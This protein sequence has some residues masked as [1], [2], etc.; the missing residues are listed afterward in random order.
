MKNYGLD[1]R[2]ASRRCLKRIGDAGCVFREQFRLNKQTF[3][4]LC[5]DL[6]NHT[7]LRGTREI[8]VEIKPAV[9]LTPVAEYLEQKI[10]ITVMAAAEVAGVK[11]EARAELTNE[12][13]GEDRDDPVILVMKKPV[14]LQKKKKN[15]K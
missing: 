1:K 2:N 6:R 11:S 5:L 9:K 3:D 14:D 10:A 7:A 15:V 8:P 12:S 4:E 13:C